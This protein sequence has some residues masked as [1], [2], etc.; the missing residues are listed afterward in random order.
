MT[1][2]GLCMI[3]RDDGTASLAQSNHCNLGPN[4]PS[5]TLAQPCPV[6]ATAAFAS[7]VYMY[8][9]TSAPGFRYLRPLWTAKWN[10]HGIEPRFKPRYPTS[11]CICVRVRRCSRHHAQEQNRFI[12]ARSWHRQPIS[13]RGAAVRGRATRGAQTPLSQLFFKRDDENRHPHSVNTYL[14][15]PLS[16]VACCCLSLLASLA[17]LACACAPMRRRVPLV[18]G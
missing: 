5:P 14:L 15:P 1:N 13:P 8:V 12:S 7:G 9:C 16:V 6:R 3:K 2:T 10:A 11:T 18:R 17:P 4:R